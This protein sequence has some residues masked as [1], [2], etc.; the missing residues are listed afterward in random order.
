MPFTKDILE[1]YDELYPLKSFKI[2]F[3]RNLNNLREKNFKL[4]NIA[5]GTG[6]LEVMLSKDGFDS[7]GLEMDEILLK[8]ASLK[9]RQPMSNVRFLK[10][11]ASEM[12]NFLGQDFY[13]AVSCLNGRIL[14]A[15]NDELLLKI[16]KSVR[17]LL[18]T[19]GKFIIELYNFEKLKNETEA[20][21]LI[22]HSLRAEFITHIFTRNEQCYINQYVES[23]NGEMCVLLETEKIKALMPEEIQQISKK[24]GFVKC[25]LYEDFLY[26]PFTKDSEKLIAVIS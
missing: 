10:I 25:E 9:L 26:K 16:F 23:G 21:K 18:K 8:S 15:F 3:F 22:S 6:T 17:C 5:S 19:G 24:S 2:D 4:L 13:D 12:G 1:Y 11:S 7:T 14:F 20:I